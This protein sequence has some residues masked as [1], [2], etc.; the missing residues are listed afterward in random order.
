M[1][2]FGSRHARMNVGG[3][4]VPAFP[5]TPLPMSIVIPTSS[6]SAPQVQTQTYSKDGYTIQITTYTQQF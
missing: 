2:D 6:T 5:T 1:P 3:F 4:V